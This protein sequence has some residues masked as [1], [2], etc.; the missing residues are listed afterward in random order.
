MNILSFD[1]NNQRIMRLVQRQ[2]DG[3]TLIMITD[4]RGENESIDDNE[5]FI[6]AGDFVL[7]VDH[8]RNCKRL[9]LPIVPDTYPDRPEVQPDAPEQ[10]F[11]KVR[12]CDADIEEAL[13]YKV[14]DPSPENIAAVRTRL[15]HH[16]FNDCMVEAGWNYIHCVVDELFDEEE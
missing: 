10:W 8:Y 14:L 5:A 2:H 11:G 1:V 6:S 12:W 16:S 13:L 3:S 7:L 9:G 4:Q 15:A